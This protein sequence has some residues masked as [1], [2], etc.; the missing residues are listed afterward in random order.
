MHHIIISMHV[1]LCTCFVLHRTLKKAWLSV[2]A[3]LR[4]RSE[5]HSKFA[6]EVSSS[7]CVR[8]YVHFSTARL[9]CGNCM[10]VH[11]H[12]CIFIT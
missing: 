3:E 10:H 2:K 4:H 12:A 1:C 5:A 6:N 9:I 8:V 7:T 11:V